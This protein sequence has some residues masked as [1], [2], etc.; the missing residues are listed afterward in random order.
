MHY[1]I[2]TETQLSG[3]RRPTRRRD[4]VLIDWVAVYAPA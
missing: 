1:V 4:N 2:Q 3:A